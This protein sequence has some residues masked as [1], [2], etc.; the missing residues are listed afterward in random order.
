[1]SNEPRK[2]E[3]H[4]EQVE[5]EPGQ[6]APGD[7]HVGRDGTDN[8]GQSPPTKPFPLSLTPKRVQN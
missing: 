8:R 5:V 6:G 1:M 3:E 7:E 4:P 2:P